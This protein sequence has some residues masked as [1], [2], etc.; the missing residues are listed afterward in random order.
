MKSYNTPK[1]FDKLIELITSLDPLNVKVPKETEKYVNDIAGSWVFF[2]I[3]IF[4]MRVL[5]Y[6]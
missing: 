2:S 4:F 5:W 1:G 6:Y 3:I